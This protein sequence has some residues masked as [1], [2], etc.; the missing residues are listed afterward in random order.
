M[1]LLLLLLLL[2]SVTRWGNLLDFG[3]FSKPLS[4]INLHKSLILP[5]MSFLGNFSD[6]WQFF[7]VHT[8]AVQFGIMYGGGSFAIDT[9]I[10]CFIARLWHLVRGPL[11]RL[12]LFKSTQ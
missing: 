11:R 7:S 6:I 3:N 8:V 4:T 9:V 10:P 5:V 12:I 2:F 1:L